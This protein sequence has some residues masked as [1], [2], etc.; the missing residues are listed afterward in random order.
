M[1]S[2]N[3]II[4]ITS[5]VAFS[6]NNLR[7]FE[8]NLIH[9]F[10]VWF[11]SRTFHFSYYHLPMI[12]SLVIKNYLDQIALVE[13]IWAFKYYYW[14]L[15]NYLVKL[16]DLNCLMNF[17][18]IA[19]FIYYCFFLSIF[20]FEELIHYFVN[21]FPLECFLQ[22]ANLLTYILHVFCE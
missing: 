3:F 10:R 22:F 18:L 6:F 12:L 8:N 17:P 9:F 15:I 2:K 16:F 7:S 13:Q 20:Y 19:T 1:F 4:T 14:G 21:S 5:F 11:H